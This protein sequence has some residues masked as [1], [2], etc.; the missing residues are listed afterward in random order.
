MIGLLRAPPASK[1]P[2]RSADEAGARAA[3][4]RFAE[5]LAESGVHIQWLALL[6]ENPAAV[7]VGDLAIVL[8]EIGIL[9]RPAAGGRERELESVGRTL[10]EYRPLQSIFEPGALH[11]RDVLRIGRMLYVAETDETNAEGIAQLRDIAA[12]FA[13]QVEVVTVTGAAHLKS[14]C[15]FVKPHFLLLNPAWVDPKGFG[16]IVAISIEEKEP[17]AADTL[18]VGPTV[19]LSAAARRTEKRLREAGLITRHVDVSE[20]EH[21]G[22][23]LTSLCLLVEPRP[24][25]AVLSG[26]PTT[27]VTTRSVPPPAAHL[28][29]AV[30]HGDLVYVSLQLPSEHRGTAGQQMR[31]AIRNLALV[32]TAAGSS[33]QGTV[34]ATVHVADAKYVPRLEPVYKEMFGPS[35][36]ARI[37]VTNGTLP[38]GVLV[39]I[40]AIA[41]L[42]TDS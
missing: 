18:T 36:P 4:L 41:A 16:N 22:A 26:Q 9:V 29:Q 31:D 15:S 30:V 11:A 40:S 3:E 32:L 34:I 8:P 42:S 25:K 2:P 35:R 10:A 5:A 23:G 21:A 12:A 17:F 6:P 38:P 24:P 19:I 20:F 1:T 33:L 7:Y 14:A 39:A 13:Y 37:L 28:S 27:P